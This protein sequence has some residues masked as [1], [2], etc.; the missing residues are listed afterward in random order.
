MRHARWLLLIFVVWTDLALTT[1]SW[2]FDGDIN[3]VVGTR[4]MVS[5][6]WQWQQSAL[7]VPLIPELTSYGYIAKAPSNQQVVVTEIIT[8]PDR[9]RALPKEAKLSK[10]GR[11]ITLTKARTPTKQGNIWNLWTVAPGDPPGSYSMTVLF[12]NEP[13]KTFHFKM[14]VPNGAVSPSLDP[15]KA[16]SDLLDAKRSTEGFWQACFE[17]PYTVP[18][19]YLTLSYRDALVQIDRLIARHHQYA[20]NWRACSKGIRSRTD[21]LNQRLVEIMPILMG[22]KDPRAKDIGQLLT[23]SFKESSRQTTELSHKIIQLHMEL[24]RFFRDLQLNPPEPSLQVIDVPKSVGYLER[25]VISDI[26][27][28]NDGRVGE[29]SAAYKLYP[30][31]KL[32]A[33]LDNARIMQTCTQAIEVFY[34]VD[35]RNDVQKLQDA[36]K[37]LQLAMFQAYQV[38]SNDEIVKAYP[39]V[40]EQYRLV[41]ADLKGITHIFDAYL[42]RQTLTPAQMASLSDK[43][44]FPDL[45]SHS[46]RELEQ[47]GKQL[48]QRLLLLDQIFTR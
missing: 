48:D 37:Q 45:Y 21:G 6:K 30:S 47:L 25:G 23:N 5:D 1:P 14:V 9:P 27:H 19:D 34:E 3:F 8:L 36:R 7:E 2:A 32:A 41:I 43:K 16:I 18:A 22:E 13:V 12:N 31:T 44:D 38:T 15:V 4:A 24:E 40:E 26:R 10:D 35:A 28:T 20:D 46:T 29:L 17:N 42:K 39:E 33:R 11:T